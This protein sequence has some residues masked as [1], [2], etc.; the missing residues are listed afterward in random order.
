LEKPL[1]EDTESRWA[2]AARFALSARTLLHLQACFAL[3]PH[4]EGE[5]QLTPFLD[6]A[7]AA[8]HV[9][10]AIPLREDERRFDC[11]DPQGFAH[12]RE[13]LDGP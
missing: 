2:I 5:A 3:H 7:L 1:P 6:D 13:V 8:G 9:G 11:G 12:A 4:E 10:L